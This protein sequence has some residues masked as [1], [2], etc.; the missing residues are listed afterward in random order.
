M[1][2]RPPE[3]RLPVDCASGVGLLHPRLTVI[4]RDS[5]TSGG[6]LGPAVFVFDGLGSVIQ[7]YTLLA[8]YAIV[9]VTVGDLWA[10][11]LHMDK[12][13]YA[14]SVSLCS[15]MPETR[16]PF[17]RT[18][19]LP[20]AQATVTDPA[21]LT[22]SSVSARALHTP[23]RHPHPKPQSVTVNTV[24]YGSESSHVC[25]RIYR[26][27]LCAMGC[28]TLIVGLGDCPGP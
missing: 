21:V 8:S 12:V 5:V 13:D 11:H 15:N 3:T 14:R 28:A 24:L 16:R 19:P 18:R 22:G 1:G 6:A 2:L 26:H 20:R 4:L 7:V 17:P 23:L 10:R 27:A 25:T 9:R